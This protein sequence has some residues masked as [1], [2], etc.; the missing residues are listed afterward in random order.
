MHLRCWMAHLPEKGN[1]MSAFYR[2]LFGLNRYPDRVEY[3]R[4]RLT[5]NAT[6]AVVFVFALFLIVRTFTESGGSFAATLNDPPNQIALVSLFVIVVAMLWLVRA[7]FL[8]LA[9]YMPPLALVSSAGVL[10]FVNGF[11]GPSSATTPALIIMTGTLLG[12]FA[13]WRL[14]T[15]VVMSLIVLR[16]LVDAPILAAQPDLEPYTFSLMIIHFIFMG[17]VAYL[18]YQFLNV[19]RILRKA[20]YDE[21][22]EQRMNLASVT[23]QLSQRVARRLDL[24]EVLNTAIDQI[25]TSYP[26]IYHA[27][28]FLIDPR[29]VDARLAAST[30]DVG[31][32]LL[33][34]KHSLPVGSQS[35]IG[36]VTGSGQ[37]V[38]A[39]AGAADGIH[40]RNE[41]LPDT[42]VEA[43][44]P[45]RLG[46]QIIGALDLQSKRL[47]AFT[48]EELPIF[49]SLA[50]SI[51]VAID[52]ARLVQETRAQLSENQRLAEEARRAAREAERLNARL[53]RDTWGQFAA[54]RE[55]LVNV[56]Y[57]LIGGGRSPMRSAYSET[58]QNAASLRSVIQTET[59]D[60]L[61]VSVPL[62]VRGQV[63]G[64]IE[65]DLAGN[66]PLDDED[67]LMVQ[68]AA[69]RLSLSAE[70][71]RLYEDAQAAAST[72]QRVNAI[73]AQYQ[74]VS[75]IEELLSVT[76]T[77]LSEVLN[78]RRGAIRFGRE[79]T[80]AAQGAG[81]SGAGREVTA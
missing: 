2:S 58:M 49:E 59:A 78:A 18:T 74:R 34:R 80:E 70:A 3:A 73:S 1:S 33:S 12:S 38:I 67:L 36:R 50:S 7:Q 37:N 48:P 26:D 45:L 28:I 43:A 55:Q 17:G 22:V 47:E 69:E 61:T 68:T 11:S 15:I 46:D 72:E 41:L 32:L 25:L 39:R 8:E 77:E 21:A 16:F 42:L 52:N 44:F 9:S 65:F 35:V 76:V 29:G 79:E 13:G 63:V 23:A 24:N 5:V 30:G 20:G 4:A 19:S 62:S 66:E 10:A 31:R 54:E 60:G 57:D 51:A 6:L 56:D 81:I 53:T 75:S 14:W 71:G 27:Q 40:R 64:V